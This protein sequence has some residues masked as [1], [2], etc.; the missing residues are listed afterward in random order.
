MGSGLAPGSALATA[1][2]RALFAAASARLAASREAAARPV[3]R[4]LRDTALGRHPAA[5]RRWLERIAA[6]RAAAA[7]I[8]ASTPDERGLSDAERSAEASVATTWMSMPPVLGALLMRL[9]AELRPASCLE[10]GSA[11]GISTAYQ[12]A[13]LELNAGGRVT[14]LDIEGMVAIATPALARL[15]LESRVE[16]VGGRIEETL[17]AAVASASPIG[18][19]VLDADHTEEPTV[20]AFERIAPA[21]APGAVVVVDDIGW[22]DGMRRAWRRIAA[23]PRIAA[24]VSVKR[25]GIAVAGP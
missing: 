22:T 10:L 7:S 9:V 12:A 15:G 13:A 14:G 21:L 23:D 4:A 11:F 17:A 25:A 18:L 1:G 24:A 2:Q 16:L 6:H 8:A 19:A 3:A 20:S 5:E